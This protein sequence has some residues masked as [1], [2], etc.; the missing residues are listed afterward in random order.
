[1]NCIE[2]PT[3]SYKYMG[4]EKYWKTQWTKELL[5][6]KRLLH[7]A[8]RPK[9]ILNQK[10]SNDTAWTPTISKTCVFNFKPKGFQAKS[11]ICTRNLYMRSGGATKRTSKL[12][13]FCNTKFCKEWLYTSFCQTSNITHLQ[14]KLPL[15]Q[16]TVVSAW[17]FPCKS[18][19]SSEKRI[20]ENRMSQVPVGTWSSI[21]CINSSQKSRL[22]S[23]YTTAQ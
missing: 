21:N 22:G 20:W 5:H 15:L 12:K 13:R 17:K 14:P 7:E 19:T 4:S 6:T 9:R 10:V 11:I 8:K 1:M 23:N 3:N 16:H 18:P 2:L